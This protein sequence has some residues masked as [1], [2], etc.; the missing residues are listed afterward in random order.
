MKSLRHLLPVVAV[1]GLAAC[2]STS[3]DSKIAY[4]SAEAPKRTLEVPPDLTAPELTN[5]Y[6]MPAG[7]VSAKL[8]AQQQADQAG[9][10]AAIRAGTAQVA[11]AASDTV[12]LERAGGQ[13]WLSVSG[14]SAE[15]LWPLVREFWQDNG[16]VLKRDEPQLG[17][18]ETD[19]AENRAKIPQDGVRKLLATVG[20]DGLYATPERDKFRTRFER[21]SN[22]NVEI[23]ISHRGMVESFTEGKNDTKWQPRADD[24]ELEAEFLGRLMLALGVDETK[25]KQAKEDAA[26]PVPVAQRRARIENGAVVVD[27]AFDRAWRRTGL[28]LDRSGLVVV[29]RNRASGTYFVR[30]AKSET[31][32]VD[33]GGFWSSLAFWRDKEGKTAAEQP[34]YRIVV[35][36]VSDKESRVT[37]QGDKGEALDGKLVNAILPKLEQQLR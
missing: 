35:Q 29:D 15:Q 31:E 9:Q 3:D 13:R 18:M 27:D 28:A 26:Q 20:L 33:E 10:Q 24:P 14:K 2:A 36:Q 25:A 37:V 7:G 23:Y 19:W 22:G 21:S 12:R 1:A 6:A 5:S 32:K 34:G 16:F 4:K 30:P 11:T 17:I 8:M